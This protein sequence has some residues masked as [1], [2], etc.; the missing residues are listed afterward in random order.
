M[1]HPQQL[2]LPFPDTADHP[3]DLQ[4]LSPRRRRIVE[5]RHAYV[6][7][8]EDLS[9]TSPGADAAR[10]GLIAFGQHRNDPNPPTLRQV[11]RWRKL[12]VDSGRVLLSL[13]DRRGLRKPSRAAARSALAEM[14]APG[15]GTSPRAR[16]LE[17]DRGTGLCLR[18]ADRGAIT[19][20]ARRYADPALTM[21]PVGTRVAVRVDPHDLDAIAV[22][23]GDRWR[24][25]R[26]ASVDRLPARDGSLP[27]VDRR[28][29][30]CMQGDDHTR[31]LSR[32]DARRRFS[33]SRPHDV[34][35]RVGSP[36]GVTGDNRDGSEA[37]RRWAVGMPG[38]VAIVL[39]TDEACLDGLVGAGMREARIQPRWVDIPPAPTVRRFLAGMVRPTPGYRGTTSDLMQGALNGLASERILVVRGIERLLSL[40]A[41]ERN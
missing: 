14:P 13:V 16:L 24:M 11:R 4:V 2:S 36:R 26:C 28:I 15:Q 12:F 25:V 32:Y 6:L 41:Y 29:G 40:Q 8:L 31:R 27:A 33:L 22:R 23:I 7:V 10:A 19:F 9:R 39:G 30:P 20:R 34:A 18:V 5:R 1:S 17:P 37:L 21:L 35:V 38:S 3:E